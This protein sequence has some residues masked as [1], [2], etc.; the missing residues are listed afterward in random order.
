MGTGGEAIR[1]N[2]AR[3]AESGASPPPAPFKD[4][5]PFSV[6]FDFPGYAI[7]IK[8]EFAMYDP[9]FPTSSAAFLPVA[10]HFVPV[11][12]LCAAANQ[13]THRK[14][15]MS[16]ISLNDNIDAMDWE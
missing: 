15:K 13:Q 12:L 6:R 11:A 4:E 3:V 1:A 2:E 5:P 8:L 9:L 14:R 7:L 16:A 10:L